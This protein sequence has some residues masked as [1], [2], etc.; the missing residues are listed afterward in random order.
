MALFSKPQYSTVTVKKKDIPKDLWT[1]CPKSGEIIYNRQL[2]DNLMV[3]PKS[4]YHFTLDGRSRIESL[5]DS[6][7][8]EEADGGI[9]S[10]DPLAFNAASSSYPDKVRSAQEKTKENDT[11]IAGVG[12]LDGIAASLA[13]MD[14]R[15][16]GASMGSAAGE[17]I[18]R[19]IERADERGIPLIIVAASGG[20][21]MQEGILS[22][23]QMAKTCAALGRLN[24]RGLPF[25]SILTNPT[26][27]GVMASFASLG[28]VI[29]S[30]PEALIGFAG[31]RVIKE[32]TQQDL[33]SDFQTAEFLRDRGLIDMIVHRTEMRDR[34][35]HLLR[36]LYRQPSGPKRR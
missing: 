28:D 17:K 15:F 11:V 32:T 29:I 3:V 7:S 27:A 14:F 18:A 35:A 30:E 34:V 31:P 36:A 24:E 1:K 5:V 19:A 16:M 12:A 2:K 21:R 9:A 33:P 23:M 6:G 8:F 22:L 26:M 4:G 10:L 13:V 20:A 25:I